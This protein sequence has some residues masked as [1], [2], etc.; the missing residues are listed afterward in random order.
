MDVNKE[1]SDLIRYFSFLIRFLLPSLLDI[2]SRRTPQRSALHS[3]SSRQDRLITRI[4]SNRNSQPE[5]VLMLLSNMMSNGS[6]ARSLEASAFFHKL[7]DQVKPFRRGL[8]FNNKMSFKTR[9]LKRKNL[10]LTDEQKERV[11]AVMEKIEREHDVKIIYAAGV[12]S[13]EWSCG[14]PDSPHTIRFVYI[15]NN[16]SS[17]SNFAFHYHSSRSKTTVDMIEGFTE[18][19]DNDDTLFEL[20]GLDVAK[21]LQLALR[22][23]PTIVELV[24]SPSVYRHSSGPYHASFGA[25]VRIVLRD[26]NRVEALLGHYRAAAMVNYK[27]L[28]EKSDSVTIGDYLAVVRRLATYEWL[29]LKHYTFFF[30]N[31]AGPQCE[32]VSNYSSSLIE[33][34]LNKVI[35]T[36]LLSLDTNPTSSSGNNEVAAL[37]QRREAYEAIDQLLEQKRTLSKH[38]RVRRIDAI[39]NWIEFVLGNEYTF[40]NRIGIKRSAPSKTLDEC[41][42]D[43]EQLFGFF[44]AHE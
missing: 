43:Y 23:S 3:H 17:Y 9:Q 5:N 39:D 7:I 36:L 28:I 15:R 31:C 24:S 16:R 10:L 42:D 44:L 34:N 19:S 30:E 4:D 2:F 38:I 26:Q 35:S 22:T 41:W 32:H 12:G 18:R 11:L 29:V 6:P 8:K 1:I 37:K 13:R 21:A 14:S 27:L 25:L 33:T 20:S 40:V